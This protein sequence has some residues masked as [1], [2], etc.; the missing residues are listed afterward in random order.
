MESLA[1]SD[2]FFLVTTVI[3]VLIG[4]LVLA[5]LV[6][7]YRILRLAKDMAKFLKSETDDFRDSVARAKIRAKEKGLVGVLA[8]LLW[9][10]T[11]H[12]KRSSKKRKEDTNAN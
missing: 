11:L 1:K 8:S 5:I 12:G 10:A 7:I 9:G 3:V 2:I 4:V 6:R